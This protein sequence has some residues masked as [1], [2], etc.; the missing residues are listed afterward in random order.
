MTQILKRNYGSFQTTV[1]SAK[2][3]MISIGGTIRGQYISVAQGLLAGEA[4]ILNP[5]E[6]LEN[7]DRVEITNIK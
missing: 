5:P 6:V 2:K 7:G 4:I 3:E 1:R